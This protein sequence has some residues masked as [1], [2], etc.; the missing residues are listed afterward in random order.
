MLLLALIPPG[1][2]NWMVRQVTELEVN[3][4]SVERVVEYDKH[5]EEAPPGGSC[6]RESCAILWQGTLKHLHDFSINECHLP[7]CP[8]KAI[9]VPPFLIYS[10]P[11]EPSSHQ[12]ALRGHHRCRGGAGSV[13]SRP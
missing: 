3:M 1:I 11:W 9:L 6:E 4:N 8:S 13:P 12:L 5:D 7:S 2:M 10:H